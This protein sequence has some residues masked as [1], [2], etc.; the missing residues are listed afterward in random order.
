MNYTNCDSCGTTFTVKE[1][2]W[3]PN[4]KYFVDM[5]FCGDCYKKLE[6]AW[7]E[8]FDNCAHDMNVFKQKKYE[9]AKA[10][11]SSTGSKKKK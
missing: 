1:K 8:A 2:T 4:F 10:M 5:D 9:V 3:K 6:D 11:C 7:E